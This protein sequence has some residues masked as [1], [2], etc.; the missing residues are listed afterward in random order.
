[1]VLIK[2]LSTDFGNRLNGFDNVAQA[3]MAAVGQES[4][5]GGERASALFVRLCHFVPLL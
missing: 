5:L 3:G 4:P 2:A 1:V